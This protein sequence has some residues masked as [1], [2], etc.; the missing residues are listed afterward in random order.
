MCHITRLKT[1]HRLNI[2]SKIQTIE[3]SYLEGEGCYIKY[4]IFKV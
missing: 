1:K 2:I 4:Q 3:T